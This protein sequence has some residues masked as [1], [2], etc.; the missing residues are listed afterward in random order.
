MSQQQALALI[1]RMTS[2]LL[3]GVAWAEVYERYSKEFSYPPGPK[4]GDSTKIGLYGR[5]VLG[6]YRKC[7][8]TTASRCTSCPTRFR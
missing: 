8:Y 6:L 7:A 3:R 2:D 1:A 4:N 5:L